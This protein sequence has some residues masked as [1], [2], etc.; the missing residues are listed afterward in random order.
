MYNTDFKVK[1]HDIK[2][3]LNENLKNKTLKDDE[4]EYSSQDILDICD[5]LYRDELCSVF[6]AENILDDKIDIYM[7]H[8][9]KQML[10]N[11]GF[12]SVIDNITELY[13]N[14][15]SDSSDLPEEIIDSSEEKQDL[16]EHIDI[17]IMF[18]LF[19]EDIFY[20]T[21]KCICQQNDTGL[22][23]ANLLTELHKQTLSILQL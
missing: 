11:P 1:Y 21:H 5:K 20:M 22:I 8:V 17:I 14:K 23:D 4:Y 15:S 19:S 13:F 18:T 16:R 6:Y 12:K 9:L 3:E 7:K 2:E 10:V